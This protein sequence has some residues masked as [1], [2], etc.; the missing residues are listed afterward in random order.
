MNSLSSK[1]AMKDLPSGGKANNNSDEVI[2]LDLS[3]QDRII[4]GRMPTLEIIHDRFVRLFRLTMSNALHKVIDVKV[5]SIELLKFGEFLKTLPV[6]ISLNLF[7]MNP[8]RGN[9]IMILETQLVFSLIDSF[10]GGTGEFE[11]KM[12]GRDFTE[13]EH[14]M[15]KLVVMSALKDLQT[16]WRPVVPVQISYSRSEINPQFVAIVPRSEVVVVTRFDVEMG[17]TPLLITLCLPYSMI[18]PIRAKLNAGF[19]SEQDEKDNSLVSRIIGTMELTEINLVSQIAGETI[20]VQ[21]LL[22]LQKGDL[23][24]AKHDVQHPVDVFL[25]D[26]KKFT[27]TLEADRGK[28]VVQIAN[29]TCRPKVVDPIDQKLEMFAEQGQKSEV[30]DPIP[31]NKTQSVDAQK[32]LSPEELA[33]F[34][35]EI[36]PE[37]MTSYLAHEHPQTVALILALLNDENRAS[38]ILQDL[39]ENLR[40][41]VAYRMATLKHIPPR[42]IAEVGQVLSEEMD[43]VRALGPKPGG[44][45]SVAEMLNSMDEASQTSILK[46]IETYHPEMAGQIQKLKKSE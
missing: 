39:P 12:E 15:I 10:F 1:K 7:R 32:S 40:G 27:G 8:L 41:D 33:K 25:N 2:P 23:L 43:S 29:T 44:A 45:K 38:L 37:I 22:N 24:L 3:A 13:I 42:V 34:L 9:G 31:S 26:T 17:K 11:V 20:T 4:R 19:Q 28:Q 5:Q 36:N 35:N 30:T 16:A 14:R 46:D 6:P 18:E 21:E